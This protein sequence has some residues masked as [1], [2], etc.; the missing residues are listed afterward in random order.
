MAIIYGEAEET[1]PQQTLQDNKTGP[2]HDDMTSGEENLALPPLPNSE[3]VSVDIEAVEARNQQEDESE[4]R[5]STEANI[6]DN[7]FEGRTPEV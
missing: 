6:L 3:S 2:I 5:D 7:D 4:N 1:L